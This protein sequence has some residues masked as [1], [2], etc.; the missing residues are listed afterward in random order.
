MLVDHR[1]IENFQ[2]LTE[3]LK[4][5]N[6]SPVFL[7]MRMCVCQKRKMR[8]ARL[9][10]Q[11]GAIVVVQR[12]AEQKLTWAESETAASLLDFLVSHEGLDFHS[13]E[14]EN[15]IE[16]DSSRFVLQHT[17][18]SS[19]AADMLHALD[20]ERGGHPTHPSRRGAQLSVRMAKVL[21]EREDLLSLYD[22]AHVEKIAGKRK[23]MVDIQVSGM[24]MLAVSSSVDDE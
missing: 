19:L 11:G 6:I 23:G 7:R 9:N 13:D 2:Y 17:F 4:I 5:F 24:I 18:R 1:D 16:T 8:A 22:V 3:I 21:R 12:A 15:K 20:P 10:N 14:D